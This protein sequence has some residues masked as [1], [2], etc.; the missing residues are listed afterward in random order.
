MYWM[1]DLF[2][3]VSLWISSCHPH[4]THATVSSI[5]MNLCITAS[6]V[7]RLNRAHNSSRQYFGRR[8]YQ[9]NNP[10]CKSYRNSP[11]ASAACSMHSLSVINGR[12]LVCFYIYLQSSQG[13]KILEQSSWKSLQSV[14]MEISDKQQNV[15]S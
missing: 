7:S 6:V 5:A 13:M 10:Q 3:L 14:M 2:G 1:I 12:T 8:H 11:G 15:I 9:C 4:S